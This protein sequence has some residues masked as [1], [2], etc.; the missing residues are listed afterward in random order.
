MDFISF[1]FF[2]FLSF[3][4]SSTLSLTA[5]LTRDSLNFL[6]DYITTEPRYSLRC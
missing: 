5:S 3:S 4:S 2:F 1:L 6:R